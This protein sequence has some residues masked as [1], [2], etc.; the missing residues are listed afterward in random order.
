MVQHEHQFS[1]SL[2]NCQVSSYWKS[3][4]GFGSC[5]KCLGGLPSLTIPAKETFRQEELRCSVC[6]A[7]P[8]STVATSLVCPPASPGRQTLCS[9]LCNLMRGE[10]LQRYWLR[11]RGKTI[12]MMWADCL[13]RYPSLS[14][15]SPLRFRGSFITKIPPQPEP[16][17]GNRRNLP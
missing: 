5:R 14:N 4:L 17:K 3:I 12:Q 1:R 8:A 15:K 11:A 6:R 13:S 10:K 2:S 9:C 7:S 16:G